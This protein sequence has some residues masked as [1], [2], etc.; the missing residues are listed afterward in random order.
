MDGSAKARGR[1]VE[2]VQSLQ[3][4]WRARSVTQA[5]ASETRRSGI[6]AAV[7]GIAILVVAG[8]VGA[9]LLPREAPEE[10]VAGGEGTRAW[11]AAGSFAEWT[12]EQSSSG[13]GNVDAARATFRA[14]RDGTG[15]TARCSG[16]R[17]WTP[18]DGAPSRRALPPGVAQGGPLLAPSNVAIGDRLFVPA[19][20]ARGACA[21]VAEGAWVEVVAREPRTLALAGGAATVTAWKGV[22]PASED[23]FPGSATAWWDVDTGL[24]LAVETSGYSGRST[25]TLSRTDAFDSPPPR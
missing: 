3:A 16:E 10:S 11:P 23:G 22:A 5:G 9:S 6:V 21:L 24:V 2:V 12:H 7:G 14:E 8:V 1:A 15:W 13:D 17:T 20:E 18:L 19:F 4:T 25:T